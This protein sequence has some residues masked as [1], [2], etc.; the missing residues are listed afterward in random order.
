MT[1]NMMPRTGSGLTTVRR[2]RDVLCDVERS[3][4]A[5]TCCCQTRVERV[6]AI[7]GA[8]HRSRPPVA[9]RN[10]ALADALRSKGF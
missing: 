2:E 9:I 10:T 1:P 6:R 3:D 5:G 7:R 8:H 4:G